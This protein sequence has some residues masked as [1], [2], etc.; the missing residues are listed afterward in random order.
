MSQLP[1]DPA[2]LE[3]ALE[4]LESERQRL[5]DLKVARGEAVFGD[6]IIIG[7]PRPGDRIDEVR[8]DAQGREIYPRPMVG[9]GGKIERWSMI[10]TGVPRA[11]RDDHYELPPGQPRCVG[12]PDDVPPAQDQPKSPPPRSATQ[13]DATEAKRIVATIPPRDER[14]LGIVF[15]GSYK[16]Q[17]GQVYVYDADGRSL[18]ALPIGPDDNVELVARRLLREKLAGNSSGFYG[19]V[20]YPKLSIH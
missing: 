8:R 4:R 19:R 12:V 5:I 17:F 14:D 20:A 6:P 7:V 2:A 13:P 9:K 16:V 11:G 10:I 18:G 3:A 15:E 1:D